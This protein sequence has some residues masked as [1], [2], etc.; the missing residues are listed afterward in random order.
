MFD[1]SICV[2]SNFRFCAVVSGV[3]LWKTMKNPLFR[4]YYE[5][6]AGI[7][8]GKIILVSALGAGLMKAN[9]VTP[10]INKIL[11]VLSCRL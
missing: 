5:E 9:P 6:I 11:F 7:A 8:R 3:P 10:A 4:A 1:L 2:E